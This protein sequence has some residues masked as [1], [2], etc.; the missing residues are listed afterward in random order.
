MKILR[1]IWSDFW[2]QYRFK[3]T[4]GPNTVFYRLMEMYLSQAVNSG[5][6]YIVFGEPVKPYDVEDNAKFC[7]PDIPEESTEE[8][9]ERGVS[10]SSGFFDTS[11]ITGIPIWYRCRNGK[12]AEA[13]SL[14][15]SLLERLIRCFLSYNE[16]SLPEN[17]GK[18]KFSLGM[19]ENYC[20]YVKIHGV[21][22]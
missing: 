6:D 1:Q 5:F 8:Y 3:T 19:Q 2:L 9:V 10:C 7:E 22:R 12:F 18:V 13:A 4:C 17:K 21:E 11:S 14:P 16:I 15:L 20:Y